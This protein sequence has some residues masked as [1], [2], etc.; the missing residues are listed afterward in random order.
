MGADFQ[1]AARGIVHDLRKGVGSLSLAQNVLTT[2]VVS[3]AQLSQALA[4][5]GTVQ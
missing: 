1:F 3:A 5:G 2:L 4:S